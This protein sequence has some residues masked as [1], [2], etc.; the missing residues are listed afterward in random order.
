[1]ATPRSSF[2]SAPQS[3]F[4]RASGEHGAITKEMRRKACIDFLLQE[5]YLLT[6]FELLHE[7]QEDGLVESATKLQLFFANSD[8]FPPDEL[9][10]MQALQGV[11]YYSFLNVFSDLSESLRMFLGFRIIYLAPTSPMHGAGVSDSGQGS[12]IRTC[13]RVC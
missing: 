9:A 13:S 5:N 3:P 7:L 1:M 8:M 4:E 2:S 10:K 11:E 6:A 12:P